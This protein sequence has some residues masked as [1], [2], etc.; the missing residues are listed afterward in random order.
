MKILAASRM[1]AA[2]KKVE[3]PSSNEAIVEEFM[4]ILQNKHVDWKGDRRYNAGF[5]LYNLRMKDK[6]KAEGVA[7]F[8]KDNME[9][10]AEIIPERSLQ[11]AIMVLTGKSSGL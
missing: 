1:S 5:Y 4:Q 9:K 11:Q 2:E 7:K 10:Y 3:Y 6:A 8:I